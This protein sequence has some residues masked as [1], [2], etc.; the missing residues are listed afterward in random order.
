MAYVIF[1]NKSTDGAVQASTDHTGGPLTVYV[2]VTDT[3]GSE[4]IE[5]GYLP[6][7]TNGSAAK[8]ISI[9]R[10]DWESGMNF[11]FYGATEIYGRVGGADGSTDLSM[12]YNA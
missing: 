12:E 8:Y 5:L 7:T 1:S 6:A 4:T 2:H 9:P 3:N 11:E 10:S